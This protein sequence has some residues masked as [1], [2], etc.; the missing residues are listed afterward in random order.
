MDFSYGDVVGILQAM[1]GAG[2]LTAA[3]TEGRPA[4]SVAFMLQETTGLEN[5]I[6]AAPAVDGQPPAN[7]TEALPDFNATGDLPPDGDHGAGRPQ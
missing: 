4:E 5:E 2:Q 6:A 1:N 3:A 7:G